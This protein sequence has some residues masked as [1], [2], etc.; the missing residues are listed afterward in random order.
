MH[1]QSCLIFILNLSNELEKEIKYEACRAFYQFF[2]NKLNAFNN[3]GARMFDSV[4]QMNRK[5]LLNCV[6][7]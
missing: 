7:A 4:N 2:C 6:L 3:T 5:L 1:R